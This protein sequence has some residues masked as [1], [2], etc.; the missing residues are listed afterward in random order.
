VVST[1]EWM[2][3]FP[4]PTVEQPHKCINWKKFDDWNAERRVDL[5]DL[6]AI[7][8]R[9]EISSVSFNCLPNSKL[10]KSDI[11][12]RQKTPTLT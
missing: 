5:F 1:F 3:A 2:G 6:D 9:P 4:R 11:R 10:Q 7:E 12:P 8:G